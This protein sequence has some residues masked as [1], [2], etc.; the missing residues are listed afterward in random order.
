M[1][2]RVFFFF[3]LFFFACSRFSGCHRG[4]RQN[5][6]RTAYTAGSAFVDGAYGEMRP[7]S[8]CLCNFLA[9]SIAALQYCTRRGRNSYSG[10]S[11]PRLRILPYGNHA[12][13]RIVVLRDYT[14]PLSNDSMFLV[15]NIFRT[16]GRGRSPRTERHS[17]WNT[18]IIM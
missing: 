17:R 10:P 2:E 8:K 6:N 5:T 15:A 11:G 14:A 7:R 1:Y 16:P 9:T 3:W 12:A 4:T 18:E 13:N